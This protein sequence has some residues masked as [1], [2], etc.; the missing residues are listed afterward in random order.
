MGQELPTSEE[1]EVTPEKIEE[2]KDML[3][4]IRNCV[5]DRY[6]D[7]YYIRVLEIFYI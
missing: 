3:K 5:T 2:S 4:T 7:C 1:E 6:I